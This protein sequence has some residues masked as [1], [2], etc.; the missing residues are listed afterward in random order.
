M[1]RDDKIIEHIFVPIRDLNAA[2]ESRRHAAKN[3][4]ANL[5]FLK[6]LR[7]KIKPRDIPGGLWHTKL[8]KPGVQEE[9]LLKQ[10]CKLML[11]ISNASVTVSSMRFPKNCQ[12][13]L[14]IIR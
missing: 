12:R 5:S 8:S 7:Q 1:A 9:M 11:A 3:Q 2:A 10:I 14:M 13:S 6:R 4:V